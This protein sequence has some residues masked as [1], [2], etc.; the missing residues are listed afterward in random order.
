M[1][2]PPTHLESHVWKHFME[3]AL[4]QIALPNLINYNV[5]NMQIKLTI[6]KRFEVCNQLLLAEMFVNFSLINFY[7]LKMRWAAADMKCWLNVI[8][9]I[10]ITGGTYSHLTLHKMRDS[11]DVQNESQLIT[12]QYRDDSH[13]N[14]TGKQQ[15]HFFMKWSKESLWCEQT[16]TSS[17]RSTSLLFLLLYF[18]DAM[19]W[20][21]FM[22]QM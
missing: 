11:A 7:N 9:H 16:A 12:S 8:W 6:I 19:C 3:A 22:W 18:I 21:F 17:D 13:R 5:A 20:A 14:F 15:D 2:K 4:L 1:I 10:I